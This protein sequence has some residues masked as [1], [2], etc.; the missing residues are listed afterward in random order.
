MTKKVKNVQRLT[1]QTNRLNSQKIN[2]HF[3]ELT[4]KK[5]YNLP[6]YIGENCGEIIT[7]G[8]HTTDTNGSVVGRMYC[9]LSLGSAGYKSATTGGFGIVV[10]ILYN[11]LLVLILLLSKKKFNF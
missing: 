4:I 3:C 6:D 8:L 5:Y 7:F 9:I 10:F 2:K 11:I 1:V